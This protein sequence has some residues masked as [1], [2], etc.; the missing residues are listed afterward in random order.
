MSESSVA[1][2]S[3]DLRERQ[4]G[5]TVR[6]NLA[7]RNLHKVEVVWSG[8]TLHVVAPEGKGGDVGR[9]IRGRYAKPTVEFRQM[10]QLIVISAKRPGTGEGYTKS[11]D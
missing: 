2:A 3:V 4:D 8:E 7:D 11:L 9:S 10:D 1:R 6:L 5:Y